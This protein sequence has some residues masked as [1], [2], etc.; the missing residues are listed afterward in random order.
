M[1]EEL[2]QRIK[3]NLQEGRFPNEAAVSQGIVLPI[4]Q[5]LGWPVFDPQCVAPEYALEG[6][7]VDFALCD[8][9][10]RP[11]VFLEVKG[12]GKA[13][14]G[15]RQL[16]EYAFHRGVPLAV[17]SHGQEWSFYL[18]AEE[19]HYE[20]RR[21]YKLDL[22]EREAKDGAHRLTRYLAH[23]QVLSGAALEAAR[24]D[25]KDVA[26]IRQ[27]HNTL[28]KA[29]NGLLEGQDSV[30][31]E[32]LADKVEDMCGFR[33]DP[34]TCSRFLAELPK[35]GPLAPPRPPHVSPLTPEGPKP[36][37]PRPGPSGQVGFSFEGRHHIGRSAR[38]VMQEILQVFAQRDPS[39][40][41]RFAAR[42]HGRKRR[43]IA[44]DRS[45]LYQGR[46][47]LS[48]THSVELAPGWWMGTNYSR[49]N[50]D[51]IIRL[52]CEVAGVRYGKQLRVTP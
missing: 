5:E 48:E 4:L 3:R 20:E 26:R 32:L 11:R 44:R 1:L 27:I 16:F 15:D 37:G 28:P 23:D 17:L 24:E 36:H 9:S 12:V 14:G 21:V 41:E 2:I 34:D 31:V 22:L 52:A 10:G 42:K 43:Y 33:P 49:K 50:I 19:G 25:Y 18:P 35:S 7:R 45:E 6:R 47:D 29:W 39:F 40:L 30:L 8:G 13:G 51:D 46:P 38:A